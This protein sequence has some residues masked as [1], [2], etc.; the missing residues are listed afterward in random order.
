MV[1]QELVIPHLQRLRL[2]HRVLLVRPC[3]EVTEG[4]DLGEVLQN[5]AIDFQKHLTDAEHKPRCPNQ[6]H[7][8]VPGVC[9]QRRRVCILASV[10]D[11]SNA[12]D[13]E[14][15]TRIQVVHS[16]WPKWDEG[17]CQADQGQ[18][19]KRH[20][21]VFA[22]QGHPATG[23]HDKLNDNEAETNP[24]DHFLNA[25]LRHSCVNEHVAQNST[26]IARL[27]TTEPYRGEYS[28]RKRC[29]ECQEQRCRHRFDDNCSNVFATPRPRLHMWHDVFAC[30]AKGV[31]LIRPCQVVNEG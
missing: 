4:Q 25:V 24:E 31:M 23:H 1:E 11:L 29:D 3:Q 21:C 19:V 12:Q 9:Q 30:I 10:N 18:E 26:C 13:E 22:C 6:A 5:R 15:R 17:H 16:G 14:G 7:D 8:A 2:F 20:C 28:Q 27:T